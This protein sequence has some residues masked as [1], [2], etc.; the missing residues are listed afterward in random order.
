M[1][2]RETM[3]ALAALCAAALGTTLPSAFLLR[4]DRVID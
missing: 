4:A 3:A 1:R 2:R